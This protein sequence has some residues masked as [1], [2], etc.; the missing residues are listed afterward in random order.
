MIYKVSY[1]VRGRPHPGEIVNQDTP[2]QKGDWVTLGNKQFEVVE[3][4]TL[5]PPRGDFV[6][7]HATCEPIKRK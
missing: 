2:P 4:I 6:Y 5:A 1:V 7:L 3:V